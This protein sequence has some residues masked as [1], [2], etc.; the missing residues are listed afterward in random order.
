MTQAPTPGARTYLLMGSTWLMSLPN[1][2]LCRQLPTLR[3]PMGV[4]PTTQWLGRAVELGGGGVDDSTLS[5]QH[6]GHFES[7]ML[8]SKFFANIG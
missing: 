3:P 6:G 5:L 1:G 2:Q 8:E 4:G 7:Q